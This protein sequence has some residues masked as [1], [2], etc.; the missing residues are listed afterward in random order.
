MKFV[1]LQRDDAF[2]LSVTRITL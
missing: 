1:P 2:R